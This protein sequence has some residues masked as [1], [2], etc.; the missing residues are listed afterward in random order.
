[1]RI[2]IVTQRLHKR[3]GTEIV[4]RD[5]CKSLRDAG[6]SVCV[7]TTYAGP[8]AA[9][10]RALGLPVVTEPRQ[11]PFAPDVAHL[12]HLNDIDNLFR[13]F[14]RC[15]GVYQ[16]HAPAAG[17]PAAV[18]HPN[19]RYRVGIS[20]LACQQI[21]RATGVP[22]DG[23]LGNYVDLSSIPQVTARPER[24]RRWLVVCHKKHAWTHYAKIAWLGFCHGAHCAAVGPRIFR[25]IRSIPAE[26]ARFDLVFASARCALESAAAGAG[27]IVTDYRGVAGFVTP[28]N[29]LHAWHH[30]FGGEMLTSPA[31]FDALEQAILCYD[32]Q[33]AYDAA[34]T[35]QRLANLSQGLARWE[36]IYRD[37]AANQSPPNSDHFHD[38]RAA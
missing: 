30:N 13:T 6:H 27:V 19:I 22:S 36:A 8:F 14:P 16:H 26:A 7:L 18:R 10:I 37:I 11:M 23:I 25:R 5:M 21:E 33:H 1:M 35:V 12:N 4:T 15:R 9:E 17:V 24:P 3:T 29:V 2:A 20:P 34:M 31:H 38:R 28:D 32:S